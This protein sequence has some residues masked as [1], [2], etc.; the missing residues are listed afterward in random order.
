MRR[1]E[2]RDWRDA[3]DTGTLSGFAASTATEAHL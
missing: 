2:R 1:E 3:S